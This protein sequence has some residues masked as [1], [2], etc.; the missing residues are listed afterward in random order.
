MTKNVPN[1]K[2]ERD[3]Q[4]QEAQTIPN[5]I[6]P[7]RPISRNF[8]NKMAEVKE[9]ILKQKRKKQSHI[10]EDRHNAISGSLHRNCAGQM[11]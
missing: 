3:I 4:V 2:K 11:E 7:N 9:R 10:Q 5:K 6:S 1:L 8:I